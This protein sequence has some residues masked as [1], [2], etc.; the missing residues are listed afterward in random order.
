MGFFISR[1]TAT[2]LLLQ[3]VGPLC[4]ADEENGVPAEEKKEDSPEK[5]PDLSEFRT[6]TSAKGNKTLQLKVVAR[7]DD[8][9]YKV[10]NPEGR[11]FNIK[12]SNLSRS[13]Q[14][15]LDFWEPDAIFN[16]KEAGL[17]DVLDQ[18]GYSVLDMTVVEST[19]FVTAT[20][21]GKTGKF[22]L[23]PSRG[24][25]TFDPAAAKEIGMNLTEGRINF[26]D[27]T[28]KSSRSQR[29]VIKEFK[30]G[31]VSVSSHVFEVIEVAKMFRAVPANTI[32]AIGGDMLKK[33]NALVD[34]GG[35]RLFVRAKQ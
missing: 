3:L 25:S 17:P 16:L 14:L 6:F 32:G 31:M 2:L 35:K 29:G 23:D 11:I 12:T 4:L 15:F 7:I 8:E 33:L 34:F 27:N 10:Q 9:T 5:A 22:L 13:D 28:G 18:M 19:F 30:A 20:V 1:L 21:D 24:W 26:T